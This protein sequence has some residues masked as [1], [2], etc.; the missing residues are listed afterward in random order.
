M[1]RP[2]HPTV[3]SLV[4]ALVAGNLTTACLI[5]A[6]EELEEPQQIP[7]R[8]MLEN[9]DPNLLAPVQTFVAGEPQTFLVPFVSEDLGESV[10]GRLY[11]NLNFN[12]DD[13]PTVLE[14]TYVPAGRLSDTDRR[15]QIPWIANR[16]VDAGC[17]SVTMT[18]THASNYSLDTQRPI[19]L[20]RTA[21]VT[22]W[23]VHDSDPED[24]NMDECYPP[25]VQPQ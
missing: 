6:P 25:V 23:V 1:R 8:P 20:E 18:I 22:W 14:T 19:D 15:M 9:A 11:L 4:L 5:E 10:V 13:P 2:I 17:Y 24:I 16:S 12:S 7:P 3:V 21:L